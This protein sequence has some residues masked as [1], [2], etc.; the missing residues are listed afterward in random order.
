RDVKD[1]LSRM[2]AAMPS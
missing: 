1:G 2:A